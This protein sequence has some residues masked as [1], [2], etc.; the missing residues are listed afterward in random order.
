MTETE[1]RKI[2]DPRALPWNLSCFVFV[3][4]RYYLGMWYLEIPDSPAIPHGG[5][6]TI[7]CWR[8]DATPLEW[9]I[10][11]RFRYYNSDDI[12][13]SNDDKS[14]YASKFSGDEPAAEK[15]LAG[16]LT[17]L[18]GLTGLFFVASPPPVHSLIFKGDS[19]KALSII[20]REK[21]FW[22]HCKNGSQTGGPA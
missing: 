16:W 11:W 21:P 17:E 12:W 1:A 5:N 14:W 4:E 3:S 10:T 13:N 18:S 2:K 9:I 7:Q 20:A 6:L 19:E 8:Y 15:N 22:L